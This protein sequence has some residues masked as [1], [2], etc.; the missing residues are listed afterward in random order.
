M[1]TTARAEWFAGV[2]AQLPILLG[3]VPFGVIFGAL[4]LS[5]GIPP[6]ET[7]AFSLFVFAGSA[8]FI[9]AG[10]IAEGT[11]ALIVVLTIF[12]VNLRHALYSAS[13]S[14][15]TQHLPKRWKAVLA[16]LLTDE[17][18]VVASVRYRER[19]NAHSHWYTLGTGLTLWASW[20]A[21]TAVGIALGKV[22]PENSW[23]DFAL[24]LTFVA[25]LVPLLI[26]RP[27]WIAAAVSGCSAVILSGLPYKLWILIAATLGVAAGM[28]AE[29]RLARVKDLP[30]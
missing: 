29:M 17:A 3:V 6:L 24:P 27:T 21:S 16:W 20:Q 10:L 8:Q 22:I 26:D 15:Y 30:Q 28:L 23:L 25:L 14:Q 1:K 4:A 7:Q 13:I 2:R 18:F 11:P 19:N 9:S 12:V 5:A